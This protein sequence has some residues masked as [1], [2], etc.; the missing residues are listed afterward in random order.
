MVAALKR[1]M[2]YLF[3]FILGL[4]VFG[5]VVSDNVTIGSEVGDVKKNA[6]SVVAMYVSILNIFGLLFAA[7]FFNNAALRDHRFQ[8]N[9]ILFSTPIRKFGYFFGRFCGA[10]LL[11]SMVM[12]G[13]YLAFVLGAA[14]GPLFGWIGPD[15]V[16]PTPW[17]SFLMTWVIFV[18]PNMFFAGAIIFGLATR[19]KSTIVSFLGAFLIMMGYIISL[20]LVSDMENQDLA[21]LVDMFGVSTYRLDTQYFTPFERNTVVPSFSGHILK[22]RLLWT[23]IGLLFLLVSYFRFSFAVKSKKA[24]KQEESPAATSSVSTLEKPIFTT[25]SGSVVQH[26]FSFFR[27]NFLSMLKSTTFILLMS[28]AIIML[29]ANLWGG[30]EY[31]GLQSYPVTYKMLDEINNISSLFVLIVLV[32]FSGELVWRDRDNH[33]NEVIDGTPHQSVVS[34]FAKALSLV[35]LAGLLHLA[36]VGVGMVYQ[37]FNGY[38]NF[39]LGVYLTDFLTQGFTAYL[40][41]GGVFVFI[42]VVINQ[43]YI[44]YF[45]SVLLLFILDLLFLVMKVESKMLILG[46]TPN[47]LYSDMNGFGPAMKGHLWFSTYWGLVAVILVILAGLLWP[48]GMNKSIVE[49]FQVGRKSVGKPY[50]GMLSFLGLVWVAVAGWV[51]YNTQVTNPYHTSHEIELRQ[52]DY[53][54]KFKQYKHVA[55]PSITDATYFIDVFPSERKAM[56]NCNLLLTNKT[57]QPIDSIHFSINENYDQQVNIPN[58][59]QVYADN[60]YQIYALDSPLF[61][62]DT[63]QMT[64]TAAYIAKGFENDVPNTAVIRNGTFFNNMNVLPGFGYQ[65]S[66]EI[67]DKNKRRKYDLP[68]RQRMP[69]LQTTCN[70][71]CMKN[72]LSN[73]TSDWV[74]VE[75]FI[76]TSDDQIAIAPGSLLSE[77]TENGRRK[78]HY[79]VDHRSQNFYSF[80]SADFEVARRKWQGIDIEVY[81]HY[82]HEVNVS[83][84]LDAIQRSLEYYT[85]HFGP[86]YHK[87]ARIIEFPRYASFAQAFPGTMPYSEAIGFI[88]DLEGEDKN[89]VVDAVIAHEM[90]HQYWAHQVIGATMQGSTMLS[91]SFAEYSS[92]MVMKQE[93]DPLQMKDFLKYDLQR[94]LRGRSRE[95][96][97]ELPLHKVENQ[98]HIHYGKGSLILYA[99]QEYIGEEKVNAALRGFLEEFRYRE[100]PY[101]TSHDF[102]RHL[103]PQVPDSLQYLIK[104]WFEDISLYDLRMEEA[105]YV[106]TPSGKYEVTL[107]LIAKKIKADSIG[108]VTEVPIADWIDIGLYKDRDEEDLFFKQRVYVSDENAEFHLTVDELPTKAAVDPLRILIDRVY[109]DNRKG[110]EGVE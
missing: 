83:R 62:G 12:L 102:M 27:I 68:S 67:S 44:G 15:R 93:T 101:P 13:V 95:T 18:V 78:Y 16:G 86:Y 52:V 50:Y 43:K 26:F 60:D 19:F 85:R 48:R 23:G 28:F 3:M 29:L 22:N 30:F 57:Q 9:E 84:M 97:K 47:A 81:Y 70:H 65:S 98:G 105:T 21:A 54:K 108:N 104:D 38:T 109:D 73:G 53:E 96:E 35:L 77:K 82:A 92:L 14:L 42:Q 72:Y 10:W 87:Q 41:W 4:L 2:I 80:I 36:L 24:K 89:N 71:L 17:S 37:A 20:S 1:P 76:T 40:I 91:E 31:F 45:V 5:A 49:R 88:I 75:T 66:Y 90:A 106:K 99:L 79:K 55:S 25:T 58:S 8:F 74:N 100:P 51:F 34:L 103:R 59:Q 56:I 64:S 6:P 11:S 46:S 61:P 63:L 110:V 32:F 33:L 7:A 69:E 107:R 39:E 94:Y